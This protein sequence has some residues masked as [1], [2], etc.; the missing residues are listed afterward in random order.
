MRHIHASC[1][2]A[3]RPKTACGWYYRCLFGSKARG[4]ERWSIAKTQAAIAYTCENFKK[5]KRLMGTDIHLYMERQNANGS[6]SQVKAPPWPCHW[7]RGARY[8]PA[9]DRSPKTECFGCKGSGKIDELR[10]YDRRNYN[11]FA[12]VADVRN[13]GVDTGDGFVPLAEPRGLPI[14]TSI[15]D[16][17]EEIE[18]EDPRF[19]NLGDHS[20]SHCT[21][22]EALEYDYT[23]VTQQRGVVSAAEYSAWVETGRKRPPKRY[24]DG[25]WG[26]G[27]KNVSQVEMDQLIRGGVIK[28]IGPK[29]PF[30]TRGEDGFSYYTTVQWEE[31]YRKS[32]GE[33]WFQFL[34]ACRALGEP[35]KVRFVFGFDS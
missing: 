4:D 5:E 22:A 24:S 33:A 11:F 19:V 27:V 16:S 9:T 29:G 21:L 15:R 26:Q 35:S 2:G 14:D 18:Y 20:F 3:P 30:D 10:G 34:E 17:G 23:R 25:V 6:W 28:T 8:Y 32:A 31:T 13:G 1:G 12:S 7:C